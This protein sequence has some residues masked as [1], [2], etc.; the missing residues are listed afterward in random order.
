MAI[1]ILLADD[2]HVVRR[3]IR[4]ILEQEQ[5]FIIAGEGNNGQEI[6]DLLNKGIEA[7]VLLTDLTM[8]VLNGIQLAKAVTN[9][10]PDIK[11]ILLTIQEDEGHI[12]NAFQAGIKSY[13]F[14]SAD[15]IELV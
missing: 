3:G 5:D 10:Y 8:P 7:D 9:N 6:L 2:H 15:P 14:K 1:R 4:L 11:I 13:L 12:Q